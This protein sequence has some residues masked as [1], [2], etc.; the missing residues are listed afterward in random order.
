MKMKIN[1]HTCIQYHQTQKTLRGFLVTLF[2][3]SVPLSSYSHFLPL[4]FRI[5]TF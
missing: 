1:N 5:V 3:K 4:H 2:H